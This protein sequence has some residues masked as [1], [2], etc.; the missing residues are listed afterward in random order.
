MKKFGT[1][2]LIGVLSTVAAGVGALAGFHKTVV[3]PVKDEEA[4]FEN[5]RIKS[6]R[7]GRSAHS[8]KF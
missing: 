2:V 6:A 7:K 4:K 1:G 3:K 5:T 8:S